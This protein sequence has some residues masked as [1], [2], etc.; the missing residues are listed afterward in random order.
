MNYRRR[1][2]ILILAICFFELFIC[3]IQ[4]ITFLI[5]MYIY[6]IKW[7]ESSIPGISFSFFRLHFGY[8]FERSLV[9]AEFLVFI[10]G[11][12]YANTAEGWSRETCPP[13]APSIIIIPAAV[14]F[15]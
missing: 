9:F 2:L 8:A 1:F 15:V 11:S 7:N 5:Q 14:N 10:H 4:F 13:Q 12:R 3:D 6:A